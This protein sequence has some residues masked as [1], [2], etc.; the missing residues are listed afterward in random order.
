MPTGNNI[1]I[2]IINSKFDVMEQVDDK[3]NRTEKAEVL[4]VG[5]DVDNVKVG[6]IILFKAYNIDDI[7]I[8]GDNYILI[9]AD[10]I[11]YIC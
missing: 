4:E 5:R 8:D 6:D 3:E 11:K 2:R 10:D 9:P 1:R 7:D